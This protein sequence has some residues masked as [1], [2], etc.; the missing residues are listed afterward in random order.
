MKTALITGASEGIG[1]E[2]AKLFA[3]GQINLILVARREDRLTEVAKE[4]RQ[5]GIDVKYYAKDLSK[6]EN[7]VFVYEDIKRKNITIDYLVNNAGVGIYDAYTD[8]PWENEV[9][10]LN[11]NMITPAYFTKIFAQEMKL[12]NSGRILNISSA[13]AFMSVPLMAGYS[14]SKAFVQSLSEIVNFELKLSHTNVTVTTIA[15]GFTNTKFHIDSKTT[16]TLLA[17]KVFPVLKSAQ[18]AKY[19]Y[20]KM[21][22]GKNSGIYNI[23]YRLSIFLNRFSPRNVQLRI[24]SFIIPNP[25]Q[26]NQFFGCTRCKR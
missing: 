26:N 1:Y 6:I 11:L 3:Q 12:R 8:I 10:V 24:A 20:N 21:M 4:L 7:A 25:K 17:N 13:S 2:L 16:Q 23:I 15:P 18:V 19:A 14:A 22:K 5:Y 9:E